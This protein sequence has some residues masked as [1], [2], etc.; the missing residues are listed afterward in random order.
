MVFDFCDLIGVIFDSLEFCIK[1]RLFGGLKCCCFCVFSGIDLGC[2]SYKVF[3]V[4]FF[5]FGWFEIVFLCYFF[6]EMGRVIKTY[7]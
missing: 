5:Y 3:G 2:C 7:G 4:D 1:A 6:F